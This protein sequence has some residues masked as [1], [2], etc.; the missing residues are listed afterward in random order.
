M[1]SKRISALL[2]LSA[3]CLSSVY[4]VMRGGFFQRRPAEEGVTLSQAADDFV[5]NN[6]PFGEQ[7]KQLATRFRLLSGQW[8]QNGGYIT[9]GHLL[10][11]IQEKDPTIGDENIHAITSFVE[12]NKVPSYLMLIPTSAAIHQE[13]KPMY[14][15]LTNQRRYIED[16]YRSMT[17][18]VSTVD[19]YQTLL[20]HRE[21]GIYYKTQSNLTGLGGYY[22]YSVLARR[23]GFEVNPLDW[24]E[25]QYSPGT[26]YGDL[27]QR[28]P[29]KKVAPDLVS[30]FHFSKYRREYRVVHIYPNEVKT[31]YTLY[32]SHLLSGGQ[33]FDSFLGGI[34]PIVKITSTAPY[35][36]RLLLF[37]D[38]TAASFLPFLCNRYR[39]ITVVNLSGTTP[40]MIADLDIRQ[41]DQIVFT[42]S[43]DTFMNDPS[44]TNVLDAK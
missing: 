42:Y 24:Y 36:Q 38:R 35:D 41:Y 2:L 13:E 12:T 37:G 21:E 6:F 44:I 28:A 40:Q 26:Y 33:P 8:E 32:P 4:I 1:L 5:G 15:P 3:I 16:V 31:Y 19:V 18:R 29:Y 34:S 43:V 17:G 27:Y 10:D 14:A 30:F 20:N 9:D 11:N 25:I 39:E 22:V 7:L 23:L